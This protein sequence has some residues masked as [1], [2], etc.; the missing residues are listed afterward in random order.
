[1]QAGACN[2]IIK[3]ALVQ[4]F[5]CEFCEIFKSTVFVVVV[6]AKLSKTL[7]SYLTHFIPLVSFYTPWKCHKTID[8]LMFLRGIERRLVAWNFLLLDKSI[9]RRCSVKKVL[10]KISQYSQENTYVGSLFNKVTGLQACNLIYK[11]TPRQVFSCE[12]CEIFKNNYLEEHLRTTAS[13]LEQWRQ[14]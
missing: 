5:S 8:F 1:M 14:R 2:F 13:I 3:E 7:S 11:K 4:L 10:L 6:F 12:Y 9:H